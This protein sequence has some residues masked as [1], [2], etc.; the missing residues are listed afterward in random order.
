MPKDYQLHFSNF[1][2]HPKIIFLIAIEKPA[3]KIERVK[4]YLE[5]AQRFRKCQHSL[6]NRNF[7]TS[8]P[9]FRFLHQIHG[10]VENF[11]KK[12]SY[13]EVAQWF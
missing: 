3:Q 1:D 10:K 8:H 7:C 2:F 13:L 4:K 9:S 6:E 11:R 12:Y 5:I